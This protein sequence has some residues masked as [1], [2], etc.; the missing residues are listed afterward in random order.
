MITIVSIV[1]FYLACFV[2]SLSYCIILRF[3]ECCFK[4]VGRCVFKVGRQELPLLYSK[5][6]F[7][8]FY[9]NIDISAYENK[10]IEV[11]VS[12]KKPTFVQIHRNVRKIGNNKSPI[13]LTFCANYEKNT[14]IFLHYSLLRDS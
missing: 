12:S 8:E 7:F 2:L 10:D 14:F 11:Q 13:F 6:P 9:E 1:L 3:L 4:S 5:Q